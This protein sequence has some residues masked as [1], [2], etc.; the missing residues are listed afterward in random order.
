MGFLTPED[1]KEVQKLF[2]GLVHDVRLTCFTQR[3]SPLYLPGQECETC[4]DTRLLLEEVT[5]LSSKLRL[6]VHEFDAD[7][8]LAAT[9]GVAR[10]PALLLSSEVSKGRVRF[11]GMPAGYEFA[12][13]LSSIVSVSKGQTELS[14]QTRQVVAE[15]DKEV[16]IQVFV[17]PSCRY[18]SS[19]A[20]L[21]HQIAIENEHVTA[22]VVEINEFADLAQRYVIRGVPKTVMNDAVEFIGAVP[23]DEFVEHLK[24][25]V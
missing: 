21:A 2:E 25:A 13:L 7:S 14:E 8:E 15:I 1:S 3:E 22:D 5:L 16:H 17:T 6:D 4:R 19:V 9:F 10:I 20:K 24:R 18:C 11:F 23:E 12:S